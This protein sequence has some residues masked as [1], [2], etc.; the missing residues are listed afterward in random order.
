[1]SAGGVLLN[2][3]MTRPAIMPPVL[4]VPPA[5][6]S[7]G[8]SSRAGR[9]SLGALGRE[10]F[11]PVPLQQARVKQSASKPNHRTTRTAWPPLDRVQT[12]RVTDGL[13]A[14]R[15]PEQPAPPL[16]RI[17]GNTESKA[18][19]TGVPVQDEADRRLT[20]RR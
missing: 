14:A 17:R 13:S 1:M 6:V 18:R 3:S 7:G 5:R 2:R 8:P 11:L 12:G 4:P 9:S 16:S 10:V 19:L 15:T 20:P